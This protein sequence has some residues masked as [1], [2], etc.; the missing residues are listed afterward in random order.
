[1]TI[2]SDKNLLHKLLGIGLTKSG[3]A[4]VTDTSVNVNSPND[5]KVTQDS[6]NFDSMSGAGVDQSILSE[7][8]SNLKSQISRKQIVSDATSYLSSGSG[9][10]V[11]L[12]V[13][14]LRDLGDL[15]RWFSDN[16][17]KLK[18]QDIAISADVQ[19]QSPGQGWLVF[20]AY[21]ENRERGQDD[22]FKK[23]DF[24]VNKNALKEALVILRDSAAKQN[25]VIFKAMVGQAIKSF[26]QETISGSDKLS[27]KSSADE[28]AKK[29]SE[30]AAVAE[31]ADFIIDA[32]NTK[33]INLKSPQYNDGVSDV[34]DA[35]RK[36]NSALLN[37]YPVKLTVKDIQDEGSFNSW[38]RDS[39]ITIDEAPTPAWLPENPISR[40]KVYYCIVYQYFYTRALQ[41]SQNIKSQSNSPRMSAAA[42]IVQQYL[43]FMQSLINSQES[44][45]I[46]SNGVIS[47]VTQDAASTKQ[48]GSKAKDTNQ[49]SGSSQGDKAVLLKNLT[50]ENMILPLVQGKVDLNEIKNWVAMLNDCG[51]QNQTKRIDDALKE[52]ERAKSNIPKIANESL[53][54]IKNYFGYFQPGSLVNALYFKHEGSNTKKTSDIIDQDVMPL[55]Q[56]FIDLVDA[57]GLTIA[58]IAGM[59]SIYNRDSAKPPVKSQLS[60]LD[61]FVKNQIDTGVTSVGGICGNN[62]ME[63]KDFQDNMKDFLNR[64]NAMAGAK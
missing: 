39:Q 28:L 63:F 48:D 52:V 50:Q 60:R 59:F 46:P 26:N 45:P 31:S 1:M 4:T 16:K 36:N 13:E 40:N 15:L 43:K 32:F 22:Q 20:N 57:V 23:N 24:W 37:K 51:F 58:T 41:L 38:L 5:P 7:L 33:V 21:S 17:I 11:N 14:N 35:N 29:E 3:Q 6:V 53:I 55:I 10:P 54:D 49:L 44:C 12:N 8:V 18:G 25:N 19:K 42:A 34:I 61:W 2:L 47:G 27:E 56:K 30:Q 9:Q 64:S 62:K